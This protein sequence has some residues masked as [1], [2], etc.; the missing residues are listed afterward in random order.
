MV[1]RRRPG[2]V[3]GLIGLDVGV[4]PHRWRKRYRGLLL[5]GFAVLLPGLAVLRRVLLSGLAVLL[6]RFAVL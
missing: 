6:P 5:Y 1:C 3:V 2:G 4:F